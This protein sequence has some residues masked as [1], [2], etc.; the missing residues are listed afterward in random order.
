MR[1]PPPS[2][3][4]GP[5]QQGALQITECLCTD[6]P[7]AMADCMKR[8]RF[9]KNSAAASG[10]TLA[11][12]AL[13]KTGAAPRKPN[14][15]IIHC[16]E[17]NFR[18]LGCYR[19][20]LPPEQAFMWGQAKG[21]VCETPHID[22][23]AR[24]GALCTKFYAATPVCSPS[25][26]SLLS[27]QYPQNTPVT[28]NNLILSDE[29]ISFA[30]L[31][32]Q[33]GYATGYAGKWHLDG[34]GKPQWEPK[35]NFGFTDNRY[36]FNRGHWKQFEDTPQGPRVKARTNG[37]ASYSVQGA[38]DKSFATDWLST[39]T[40]EF[41]DEHKEQPFC[42]MLSIP[43]PHGPDTV[44][45][46]YDSMFDDR[47]VEKPRTFDKDAARAPSWAKPS[48]KCNYKMAQYHGMMKCI[49]DNVG[50]IT[51]HLEQLGLLDDTI[52]IFTADHGDMR[53]EH[54]RQNKGIPL[55]ASAKVPFVIRYPK[56][57]PARRRIDKV[58]NTVD[59]LPTILAMMKVKTAGKEEGR[60]CSALFTAA[61]APA[62][63]NDVTF[64][65]S[66]G[67]PNDERVGW[68]SAVT[69]RYKLIL[70]SSDDPW[71]LDLKED[72]DELTNFIGGLRHREV[73]K[74]L[75]R[76]LIT[77]G[78]THKDPY[79]AHPKVRSQLKTLAG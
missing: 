66:T 29:V 19:D 46:P 71:L 32:K 67:K 16:D 56:N 78:K 28:N 43:D 39:K 52:L 24:E 58:V 4:P 21:A 9:L 75:A 51:R 68:I 55:E 17:L 69:P 14:L 11:T 64:M 62:K 49:D 42:Y 47:V 50:R 53:G 7:Y 65:R 6:S 73:A 31:L 35:R 41:I 63:W 59:F 37:K 79:C 70:S 34:G 30:E 2:E 61:Q 33:T 1:E 8:R 12:P 48:P 44:R 5:E 25:R 38:D 36:M 45:A 15:V 57:I 23:L 26:S 60:D 76:D 74:S 18:T 27:G 3:T 13:A 72:P 40:I 22:R 77:Y 54:H 20:T 10:A